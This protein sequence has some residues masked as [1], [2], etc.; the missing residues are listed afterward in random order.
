[1]R[2]IKFKAWNPIDKIMFH[3]GD[4]YGTTKP[5]DCVMY[6]NAGQPVELLQYTGL[7]D[8]NGR[9]IYDGD[10]VKRPAG[11]YGDTFEPFC[12]CCVF[13]DDGGFALAKDG[14]AFIATLDSCEVGNRGIEVIGNI[15][16]NSELIKD[17]VK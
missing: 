16:E 15:Y 3:I 1:M 12:I 6:K 11:Y 14:T 7:K 17:G 5:L 9:E 10:I 2:E 8:K 13:W 4:D